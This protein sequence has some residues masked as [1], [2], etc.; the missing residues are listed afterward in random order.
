MRLKA[1][2]YVPSQI[3]TPHYIPHFQRKGN[4]I[5]PPAEK[6]DSLF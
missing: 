1:S 3:F 6:M 2:L 5:L 4:G